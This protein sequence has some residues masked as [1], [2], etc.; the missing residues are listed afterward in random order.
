MLVVEVV[1]LLLTPEDQ[2]EL[3]AVEQEEMTLLQ[4][5]LLELLTLVVV[6]VEL[7]EMLT[8]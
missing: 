5:E 3:A 8:Q 2:V 4:L 6:E 7:E 1:E